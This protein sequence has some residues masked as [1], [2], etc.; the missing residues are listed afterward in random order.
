M[1]AD[2]FALSGMPQGASNLILVMSRAGFRSVVSVRHR[3]LSPPV[4]GEEGVQADVMEVFAARI[5]L[6]HKQLST[7]THTNTHTHFGMS[8]SGA[9]AGCSCC[10]F[11][12]SFFSWGCLNVSSLM[13]LLSGLLLLARSPG[14]FFVFV[15]RFVSGFV[16]VIF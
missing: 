2:F 10:A 9:R 11:L 15:L 1:L 6:Y 13:S 12:I 7:H 4:G 16:R 5:L 3:R 14:L 8:P